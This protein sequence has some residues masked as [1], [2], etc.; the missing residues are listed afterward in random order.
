[1]MKKMKIADVAKQLGWSVQY[2]RLMAQQDRLPFVVATRTNTRWRYT[3]YPEK[4]REY[5]G[6]MA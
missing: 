2:I 5:M 4:Y 6:G 1:M 3:V